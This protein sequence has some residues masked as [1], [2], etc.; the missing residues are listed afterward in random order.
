MQN[1]FVTTYSK[2]PTNSYI[3]TEQVDEILEN[4]RYDNPTES[5]YKIT[6]V[7]GSGKTVLL[8][9]IEEG[10]E[11]SDNRSWY[12]YRLSPA[13]DMLK[14]LLAEMVQNFSPEKTANKKKISSINI[15]GTVI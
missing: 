1:P 14:Q 8:A 5:V 7:R 12:V 10:I 2:I 13:R 4:F 9:K 6:G 15:S 11:N 3:P